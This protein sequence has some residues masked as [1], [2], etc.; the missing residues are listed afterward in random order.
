[1][2]TKI[3]GFN[4]I[5]LC[6]IFMLSLFIDAAL[7]DELVL[8]NGDTLTGKILKVEGDTITLETGYSEPVKIQSSKVKRITTEGQAE[9]HLISGE[10]LKGI[11]NTDENGNLLIKE[12]A[13]RETVMIGWDKVSA[14]NPP[15][16]EPSRWKGNV[17]IGATIQNG[18]TDRTNISIGADAL[19]TTKQDRFSLRFLHNYA[20]EGP[21]ITTRS[22]YGTGKYDY[23]FTKSLYGYLGVELLNDKTKDLKLRTIVGPGVGYQFW[24]DP[25]KSLM[26]E[27]GLAFFSED[28]NLGTD[29]DWLSARLAADLR[30]S[31]LDSVVFTDQLVLYPSLANAKDYK[32][33]NE[34]AL[35]SPLASG[36]SLRLAN[37][38]EHDGN[39]PDGIKRNDWY[40]ILGLL[41]SF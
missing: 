3:T 21:D 19:R 34:A 13:A 5:V 28:L 12:T 31:I 16:V 29:K 1:M 10:I 23:F 6:V 37:I 27:A 24:D 41:Y 15:Q 26:L 33:R 22:Y 32:L 35:S 14:I 39:P 18:N 8:E 20:E 4:Y 36:W 2:K 11:I 30:Y 25:V 40:W 9:I 38:L 7:C 17:N